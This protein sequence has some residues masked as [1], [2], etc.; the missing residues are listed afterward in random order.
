MSA[1][2]LKP[3]PSP[4]EHLWR[5]FRINVLPLLVFVAAVIGAGIIWR[6]EIASPMA[7][8]EV[9]A[10]HADVTTTLDGIVTE[11]KV[12]PFQRVNAGDPIALLSIVDGETFKANLARIEGNL[13]ITRA[14]LT[15]TQ[16]RN[17][18]EYQRLRLDLLDQKV[19]LAT[20]RVNLEFAESNLVRV[21]KLFEEKIDSEALYD[22]ARTSRD[23][24]LIEIKERTQLI[25]ELGQALLTLQ[26]PS[27]APQNPLVNDAVAAAEAL[28]RQAEQPI[29]LRSPIDGIVS[30]I[31]RRPG[32][33]IMAGT[34]IATVSASRSEH[35]IGFVRQPLAI[36]PKIGMTVQVR[37]RTPS[38]QMALSKVLQVGGE[39]QMVAAPVRIRGSGNTPERGLPFLLS[40]PPELKLHPG[41]LV[42]L[43][44]NEA[45]P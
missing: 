24:L 16:V 23:A 31:A 37:T 4:P 10:I 33:R 40:L 15:Q 13:K 8:G 21:K 29:L 44:L 9:E 28:L 18:Q 3:I 26:P 5:E 25:A 36:E 38:R 7:I 32:E 34:A 20:A 27:H 12:Q 39:V 35:I 6:R 2:P 1:E 19:A 42:D 30:T 22:Q 11:L 43:I 14:Q 41:E 17:D 45:V